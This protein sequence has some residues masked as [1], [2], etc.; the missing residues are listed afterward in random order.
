VEESQFSCNLQ[1]FSKTKLVLLPHPFALESAH[2]GFDE[3]RTYPRHYDR[4]SRLIVELSSL[5]PRNTNSDRPVARLVPLLSRR[6]EAQRHFARNTLL[7]CH[8]YC[9]NH[10]PKPAAFW[11]VWA[12]A[13]PSI[14][15][16]RVE[17]NT[18]SGSCL[19]KTPLENPANME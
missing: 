8:H 18:S 16:Q 4:F 13:S 17:R 9:L 2:E 1:C 14:A 10:I 12:L 7:N 5:R 3:V 11:S 19:H 15:Y 6:L